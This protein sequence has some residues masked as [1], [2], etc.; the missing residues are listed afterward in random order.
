MD[1]SLKRDI[2]IWPAVFAGHALLMSI[3]V[4]VGAEKRVLPDLPV[5][6]VSIAPAEMPTEVEKTEEKL[7]KEAVPPNAAAKPKVE[8]PI[9]K[10]VKQPPP[11]SKVETVVAVK[12]NTS[13]LASVKE[14]SVK[15][16]VKKSTEPS[17]ES[18]TQQSAANE[19]NN[20][21][22]ANQQ[23]KATESAGAPK[24]VSALSYIRAPQPQYPAASSRLN[25]HGRVTLKVMVDE[26]GRVMEINV[27]T[28]SGFS[29]LDEAAKRAVQQA[30]FKPYVENGRPLKAW[31]LVPI[32]FGIV[33]GSSNE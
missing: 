30:S 8:M 16:S 22:S 19:K 25:E 33:E 17:V 15:D 32:D 12:N 9:R 2:V 21:D 18:S 7:V 13:N 23:A 29:R 6:N 31:A 20:S 14:E 27:Q 5:V 24:R 10:V 26:F 28:S 3:L 11:S 4:T 1:F